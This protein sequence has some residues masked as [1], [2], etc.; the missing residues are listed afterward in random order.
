MKTNQF[1]AILFVALYTFSYA[2]NNGKTNNADGTIQNAETTE[3]NADESLK[4]AVLAAIKV[5]VEKELTIPVKLKVDYFKAENNFAFVMTTVLKSD[6][7]KMD[8]KG[9]PFD[10]QANEG[11]SFSDAVVCLLKNENGEWKVYAITVGAT[12]APNGCWHKEFKVAKSLFPEGMTYDD[13]PDQ[14]PFIFVDISR[15]TVNGGIGLNL[16]ELKG[17]LIQA[18][19]RM[20]K[21][22]DTIEPDFSEQTEVNMQGKVRAIITEGITEA[23]KVKTSK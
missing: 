18:L 19:L 3:H 22:P 2:C 17:E 16:E 9:T 11:G 21:I 14:A 13:C 20:D 6:G 8:F 7:G 23:K 15:I 12:D 1:F 5:P 10:E 4:A